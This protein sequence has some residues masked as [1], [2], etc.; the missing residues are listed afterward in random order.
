MNL[1]QLRYVVTLSEE[2]HFG[3]AARRLGV[4][5]PRLSQ[6]LRRLEDELGV[7]LFDRT[8]REVVITPAGGAFVAEARCSLAHAE[9]AASTARQT[10]RGEVGT[11]VLGFV[12]SAANSLL[13]PLVRQF[14]NRYP[15]VDLRLREMPSGRQV[16]EL[17]AGR[18]DLGVLYGPVAGASAEQLTSRE[19]SRGRLLAALPARHPHSLRNP[20]RVADLADE[21]FVLFPRALGTALHANIL[22]VTR[23]AGFEP[24][25]VQEAVQMQTITGLVAAGI[26]VSI[27]PWT[28]AAGVRR[29]DVIFRSLAPEPSGVPLHLAWRRDDTS[30][31][32]SNFSSL[33][34]LRPATVISSG[35]VGNEGRNR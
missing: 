14:R 15:G 7:A 4:G 10:G 27:V 23:A 11:L 8:T 33:A 35:A 19:F 6:Q 26:G 16:E 34:P 9:R 31:A 1:D 13:P 17:V 20:I 2:L 18:V 21:A 3:R 24:R 30:P 28:A 25:V 12:G 5:Q 22:Q 29:N 32:V